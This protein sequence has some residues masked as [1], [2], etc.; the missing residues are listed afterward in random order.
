MIPND[1]LNASMPEEH[2]L[3]VAP[4]L[5][6]ISEFNHIAHQLMDFHFH[7]LLVGEAEKMYVFFKKV[8]VSVM[9]V[10]HPSIILTLGFLVWMGVPLG[11]G[12]FLGEVFLGFILGISLFGVIRVF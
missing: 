11:L 10:G 12:F 9:L 8:N 7:F 6:R 2:L 3:M 5:V 4:T 1:I